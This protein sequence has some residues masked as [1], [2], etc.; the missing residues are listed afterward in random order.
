[1]LGDFY[2]LLV[3][4]SQ[5]PQTYDYDYEFTEFTR[6]V[7]GAGGSDEAFDHANEFKA[8]EPTGE[9]AKWQRRYLEYLLEEGRDAEALK[10]VNAVEDEL[11]RR[12]ARPA[13][14]R[15]AKARLELR[16]GRREKALAD[17]KAF[18]GADAPPGL[19]KVSAPDAGRLSD[20][21]ALLREE[22]RESLAPQLVEATYTQL[23]A[24]GQYQTPYFVA[25]AGVAFEGGDAERGD[26][27]LRLLVELSSD[28]TRDEAAARVAA[29]PGVRARA[30]ALGRAELPEG[31][32]SIS[33]TS[34]LQLAAETAGSFARYEEAIGF[35]QTLAAE[36][37]DDYT[38][39]VELARLLAA[40]GRRAEAVAQLSGVV[41]DRRAPRAARW[42]AMWVAPEV[43]GGSAELWESLIRSSAGRDDREMSAALEAG[44]LWAGGRAAEASDLLGRAAED[45]PNPLLEFFL[46]VVAAD[47]GRDGV[48][49]AAWA[50][51]FRSRAED[52]ISSA[53]GADREDALRE[54]IRLQ[55]SSGRA[56]SALKLASLDAELVAESSAKDAGSDSGEEES[57]ASAFETR[58]GPSYRT[59]KER[60]SAR[61]AA[62]ESELLAGLS[63]AAERSG[64]F[65][66][67]LEFERARQGRLT[68][69]AERAASRARVTK[70]ARLRKQTAGAAKPPLVVDAALVAKS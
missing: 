32:N 27:M 14:L 35:R 57:D 59:L 20:A 10:V 17:L 38:N 49:E 70:L 66:K 5:G 64:E 50:A 39:R 2:A 23:L 52:D 29:L 63:A 21:V 13:W 18:V 12:Y 3:A 15:L 9:R 36:K 28:E 58:P 44:R 6:N 7:F 68:D 55:L 51:A 62:S 61:R 47:C 33:H 30:A 26:T 46:G 48:A 65:D 67:A 8:Q 43:T 41:F 53:F 22:R 24:L 54:L 11:V 69:E 19:T 31:V 60:A 25:L 56:S 34:A 16:G 37:P 1:R 40:A 45:D 42:Q 4:R